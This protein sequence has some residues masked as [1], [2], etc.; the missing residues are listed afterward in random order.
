MESDGRQSKKN[1]AWLFYGIA[2]SVAFVIVYILATFD[3]YHFRIIHTLNEIL[4]I[5]EEAKKEGD[6]AVWFCI[7]DALTCPD[8]S[9]LT[10]ESME[11]HKSIWREETR[12][13]TVNQVRTLNM[14][15]V[16]AFPQAFIDKDA[17]DVLRKIQ[18]Q[19]VPCHGLSFLITGPFDSIPSLE[20]WMLQ[21]LARL[22]IAFSPLPRWQCSGLYVQNVQMTG[23][24]QRS[25][26]TNGGVL[27]TCIGGGD[28]SWRI[29]SMVYVV[30]EFWKS[31]ISASSTRL[32]KTIILVSNRRDMLIMVVH[33][34]QQNHIENRFIG[35]LRTNDVQEESHTHDPEALRKLIKESILKSLKEEIPK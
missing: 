24:L 23:L 28:N 17:S 19:G 31:C 4:P 20:G 25:F 35:V 26:C 13:L 7:E 11:K 8:S 9:L 6:V 27:F 1:R 12:S 5:V 21:E 18:A 3:P 34:L 10:S 32:P 16:A 15:M 2:A 14:A 22:G 30:L 33:K 29:E